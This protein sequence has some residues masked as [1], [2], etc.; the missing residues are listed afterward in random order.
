LSWKAPLA[1]FGVKLAVA[2]P[3]A[4]VATVKRLVPLLNKPPGPDAGNKNETVAPPMGRLFS[5]FT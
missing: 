5:S 3:A 2:H 1:V 4:S